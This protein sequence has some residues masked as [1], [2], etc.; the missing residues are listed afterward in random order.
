M[1]RCRHTR[2]PAPASDPT[3]ARYQ[4]IQLLRLSFSSYLVMLVE[5][6]RVEEEEVV[7]EEVAHYGV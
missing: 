5:V 3:P 1:L 6:V 7:V 4:A 2:S